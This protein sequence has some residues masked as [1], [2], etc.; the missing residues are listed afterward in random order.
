MK[1]W[2]NLCSF[3]LSKVKTNRW[4]SRKGKVRHG[5]KPTPY[6]LFSICLKSDVVE[7]IITFSEDL[8]CVLKFQGCWSAYSDLNALRSY[9][10]RPG[11]K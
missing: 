10:N 7:S 9:W 8:D 11:Q 5:G 6:G 2:T 3:C 4:S 1:L